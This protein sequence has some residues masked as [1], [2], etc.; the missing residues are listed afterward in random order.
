MRLILICVIIP[1]SLL[2][3]TP[4]VA[5]GVTTSIITYPSTGQVL[6]GQV[7]I[8]GTTDIPSFATAE[9]DFGYV[10]DE[11]STRF[12]IQ[13]LTHPIANNL[14]ATWDTT[15]ISDGDYLIL[16]RVFLTDGTFQDTTVSVKVR[17]Y[18]TLPTATPTILPTEPA[19]QIPTAILVVPSMTPTLAPLPTP[20]LLP[21][22]TAA[23]NENEIYTG[24]WRG[25]LVV[26][27]LFLIFGLVIRLRRS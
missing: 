24:F 3:G 15:S 19:I 25:G 12:L 1:V 6:Q 18:T 22:N 7:A 27:L 26:L 8:T 16:L 9:L 11:T 5:Q 23:T 13:T 2:I 17:N 4:V 20:T 14:L 10:S 21:P